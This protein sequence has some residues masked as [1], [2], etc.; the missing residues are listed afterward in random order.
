MIK[1]FLAKLKGIKLK[2]LIYPTILG[3]SCVIAL[4]LFIVSARF[5]SRNLNR[6]F[7]VDI[8]QAQAELTKVDLEK[9]TRVAKKL[10][11]EVKMPEPVLQE[12]P[13]PEPAAASASAEADQILEPETEAP[14]V[15]N[16]TLLKIV[17]L[18]GT[19][20]KG[21]AAGLKTLLE[22]NGFVVERLGNSEE[23]QEETT[24]STKESKKEYGSLLKE[25]VS[26]KY[27][28]GADE[29]LEEDKEYDA[30]IIIGK[31]Q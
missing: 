5:L 15:L 11:I 19:N 13:L 18:N 22:Q 1:N 8:D 9:F 14:I 3:T 26:Q 16:K 4:L 30:L 2:Q 10:G 21:L 12:E 29:V 6:V 28:L 17:V 7:S 20:Q 23:T 24:I 31:N 25:I 27:G